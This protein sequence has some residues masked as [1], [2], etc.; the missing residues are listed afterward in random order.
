VGFISGFIL[1]FIFSSICTS[2][3]LID[4]AKKNKTIDLEKITIKCE[5][6]K[7]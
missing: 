5:L 7:T 1:G 3:A 4:Y 2:L 6:K